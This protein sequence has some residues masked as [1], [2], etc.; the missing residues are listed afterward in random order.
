LIDAATTID[1]FTTLGLQPSFGFG[2]RI[3]LATP[4]HVHA[5]KL[6]GSG[7]A[8]FFAQQSIREMARTGRSPSEVISAAVDGMRAADW[9][10]ISGADADHLKTPA[11][12]D[13][14][15]AAGFVFYTI[16]PSQ[17]V[18]TSADDYDP[19]T[20]R[21]KY[22]EVRDKIGW[23]ERYIDARL[24][25]ASGRVSMIDA[26][27]S[28]RCAVKYGLAIEH[29]IKLAQYIQ[30]VSHASG[31]P[32]EIELSIDET[33]QPTTLAEHFII[34]DQCRRRGVE[35]IS[36]APR[37]VGEFEK[38]VDYKGSLS[39]LEASLADH[40]SLA[41]ELGPYKLSLHSGSDKLSLYPILARVTRGCF[42]VKT[43]GTSY[44]EAL[45]VAARHDESL[46]CRIIDKA[47]QHYDRD[48]ATYHV[49]ATVNTLPTTADC[50]STSELERVYLECWEDVPTGRGFIN[51]GRQ[52][53]H[54]TFG[55][56]LADV[57]LGSRLRQLLES[58]A[59]SYREILAEHFRR[60]LIALTSA[61]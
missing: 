41:R 3:G 33:P 43:A 46:F 22:R 5:M 8:P 57:Q 47:R 26:D 50:S 4:G 48:K 24:P 32:A 19:S 1:R 52:V 49:S 54:C 25:L 55:T 53:L 45:R 16:D 6:A 9:N 30:Q 28:M 59:D 15:A 13:A 11:D 61:M 34:I 38:G 2:D 58:Q 36:L 27:A 35:L 10:D 39:E 51:P 12:V 20:L 60:H 7:I 40:A 44:L 29:A 21:E 37:F 18:D 56:V 17:Y 14:T 23:A 31:R 42:H